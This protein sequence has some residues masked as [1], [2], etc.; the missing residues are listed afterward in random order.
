MQI[1][2]NVSCGTWHYTGLPGNMVEVLGLTFKEINTKPFTGL[3][4]YLPGLI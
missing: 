3:Q 2:E 4:G 1:L